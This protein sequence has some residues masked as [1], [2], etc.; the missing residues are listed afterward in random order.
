MSKIQYA[1]RENLPM[2]NKVIQPTITDRR[3]LSLH[4]IFI[5]RIS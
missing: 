2:E 3:Y 4:N 5:K 1:D